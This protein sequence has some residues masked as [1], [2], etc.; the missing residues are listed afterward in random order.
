VLT[1]YLVVLSRRLGKL[2]RGRVCAVIP[3]LIAIFFAAYI[4][5]CFVEQVERLLELHEKFSELMDGV[6][7]EIKEEMKV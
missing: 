3:G 4:A 1:A 2:R 7:A 5:D 6:N